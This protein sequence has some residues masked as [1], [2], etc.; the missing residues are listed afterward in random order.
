MMFVAIVS[1]ELGLAV[2]IAACQCVHTHSLYTHRLSGLIAISTM[3][4]LICH[5]TIALASQSLLDSEMIIHARFT[6]QW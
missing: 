2:L 3:P 5:E 4:L 1:Q 6:D